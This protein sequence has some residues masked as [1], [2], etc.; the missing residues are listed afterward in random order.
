M[1]IFKRSFGPSF[2]S[3]NRPSTTRKFEADGSVHNAAMAETRG[4]TST[5]GAEKTAG[6]RTHSPGFKSKMSK[7]LHAIGKVKPFLEKTAFTLTTHDSEQQTFSYASSR[8]TI[9]VSGEMATEIKKALWVSVVPH[10][11]SITD[12]L[13]ARIPSEAPTLEGEK[14]ASPLEHLNKFQEVWA[15]WEKWDQFF[16]GLEKR[17]ER[18]PWLGFAEIAE[19]ETRIFVKLRDMAEGIVSHFD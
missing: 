13:S 14:F 17:Q 11:Q 18:F 4:L 19:Q 1:R 3:R 15:E 9:P 7:D 2:R 5:G 10:F 16:A 6:T 12:S 8:A